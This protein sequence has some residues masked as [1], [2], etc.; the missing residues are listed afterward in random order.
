MLRPH[1]YVLLHPRIIYPRFC[2]T[3]LNVSKYPAAMLPLLIVAISRLDLQKSQT[4]GEGC[5]NHGGSETVP[6]GSRPREAV[7][8]TGLEDARG[9]TA[10]TGL[11]R[12]AGLAH[13]RTL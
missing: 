5:G 1:I 9:P 4:K 2:L 7:A 10:R 12:V 8:R 3:G 13:S 6:G 11:Q